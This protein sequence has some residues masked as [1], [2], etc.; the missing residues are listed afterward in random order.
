MPLP[1]SKDCTIVQSTCNKTLFLFLNDNFE[2]A[3]QREVRVN[4]TRVKMAGP[5]L[6]L[7]V[8]SSVC[9]KW[10]ILEKPAQVVISRC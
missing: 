10:D 1:L 7:R 9:V 6:R 2:F 5:V 8:D 3:S 4:R